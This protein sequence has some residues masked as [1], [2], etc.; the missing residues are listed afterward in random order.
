VSDPAT[1]TCKACGETK[2]ILL[3]NANRRTCRP[4]EDAKRTKTLERKEAVAYS[5]ALA[6]RIADMLAA[7][8]TVAE[9]TGQASMPTP[10][11]LRAWRRANP[12]FH[13]ACEEAEQASAAAH[14]DKAKQVLA[15]LEAGKVPSGDAK[16]LFDGH[17]K[18]AATLHPARYGAH[19]VAIDLTSAG[20]PLVDFG[21][22]IEALIAALPAQAALPAPTIDAEATEVVPEGTV[23]Q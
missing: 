9:V 22:A 8:M 15:D 17:M 12:D 11:Q 18:L 16:T 5:D 3:F 10:R 13:A 23:L 20:R 14:L 4:C 19:P 6:E 1:R 21:T 7:G 2:G